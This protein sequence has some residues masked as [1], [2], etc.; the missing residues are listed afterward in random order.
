VFKDD[1]SLSKL[2]ADSAEKAS[3]CV[4]NFGILK[5]GFGLCHGVP[6]SAFAFLTMYRYTANPVWLQRAYQFILVKKD[7][8]CCKIIE[9]FDFSLRLKTGTSDYP[10]SIMMGLAG[11]I[12]CASESIFPDSA[13]FPGYEVW[14]SQ[15]LFDII[16]DRI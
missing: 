9:N 14:N 12:C 10:Y 5:K 2:C 16:F 6:G 1:K 13:R 11:D 3:E 4:W 15:N 7:E 8:E